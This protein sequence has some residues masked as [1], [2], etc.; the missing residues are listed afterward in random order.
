MRWANFRLFGAEPPVVAPDETA[1]T[2]TL[3][4][5]IVPYTIHRRQRRR[6]SLSIDHRGLRVLGPMRLTSR[7][8]ERLIHEHA[9]WVVSKLDAWR[10]RRLQRCWAIDHDTHLPYLGMPLQIQLQHHALRKPRL[11]LRDTALMLTT[12]NALDT[13]RNHRALLLWLRERALLCFQERVAH[14]AT[15]LDVPTP[16]L[17]L[18]QAKTRW[19]SC[20]HRG[21]IRLNWRLIHLPLPLIDYVVAHELAHLKEM[22]HG[23]RFWAHVE[24]IYPDW[25][26]A[27]KALRLQ[28]GSLPEISVT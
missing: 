27:R 8:V 28:V 1:H 9:S 11:T 2:I 20:N 25:R 14:Y 5:R 24:S 19:G 26:A 13:A 17:A 15:R 4:D 6:L 23:P 10:D 12:D 3:A 16:P 21:Q 22:N 18:S 7:E